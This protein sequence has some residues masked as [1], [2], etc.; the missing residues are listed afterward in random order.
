M[1]LCAR[2]QNRVSGIETCAQLQ[3]PEESGMRISQ[4]RIVT[5]YTR[6]RARALLVSRPF[7]PI[8]SRR[9]L[10]RRHLIVM[11]KAGYK[12]QPNP[13]TWPNGDRPVSAWQMGLQPGRLTMGAAVFPLGRPCSQF[14]QC[15]SAPTDR[16]GVSVRVDGWCAPWSGRF[17]IGGKVN[18]SEDPHRDR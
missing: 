6:Q 16:S 3:A 13:V 9:N 17:F 5:H 15:R 11:S 12:V 1:R 14:S 18:D 10:K 8:G 4:L 7:C 2:Y